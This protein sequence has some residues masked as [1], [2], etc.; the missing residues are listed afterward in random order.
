LFPM[1]NVQ[2]DSRIVAL[3]K[4]LKKD[5]D[6]QENR[7]LEE[8]TNA[9]V[10]CNPNMKDYSSQNTDMQQVDD[11]SDD[12]KVGKLV[13]NSV[14]ITNNKDDTPM[15]ESGGQL[16]RNRLDDAGAD[17][18]E[19]TDI[20]PKKG[21]KDTSG[22]ATDR[23]S[24]AN[25]LHA[26]KQVVTVKSCAWGRPSYARVLIEVSAIKIGKKSW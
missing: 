22:I 18:E 3:A 1:F 25:V 24:C 14:S 23:K 17:V 12:G 26:S 13:K 7:V 11:K 10:G 9:N 2:K 15:N 16:K 5:H 20:N 19:R 6:C 21:T 8:I 4:L